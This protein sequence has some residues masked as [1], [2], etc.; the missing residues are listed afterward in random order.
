MPNAVVAMNGD[1]RNRGCAG[2]M[3]RS[4]RAR[5][6]SLRHRTS[7]SIESGWLR[8][9]RR[10]PS[11][12]ASERPDPG[13]ISL[14]VIHNISLPPGRFGGGFV[15]QLFLNCLDCT[16]HPWFER[17]RGLRVS[18]HLLIDRR[19]RLT[20]FVPFGLRAWHA[21]ESSF[22]GRGNCND[23][24]VGIELEG[25][26]ERPYTKAQYARLARVTRALMRA[27]PAITAERIVGHCDIAP[28][29]KSDPGRAF[30]WAHYRAAL[31]ARDRAGLA[32]AQGDL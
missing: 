11:E 30:D 6:P 8:G 3:S 15:E 10:L 29:R 1:P 9:A 28:G 23:F 19:G 20:Q 18:A 14:L 2:R 22:A 24:S 7:L 21:G 26:D 31:A 12:N 17:L 4:F 27:Y 13:E 25:T 5:I 32:G 16:M